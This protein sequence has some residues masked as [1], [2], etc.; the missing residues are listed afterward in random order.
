MR[1]GAGGVRKQRGK[2]IGFWREGGKQVSEVIGLASEMTK[3]D[4]RDAVAEIVKRIKK[5]TKPKLFGP[6]VEGPYFDFYT[7]KWKAST[8]ENNQQ[9]VRTHLVEALR[10]RDM[11]SIRRDE[12]QELLD[13]K[14]KT[15]SFSVVDHLRWDLKQIFDMAIAEGVLKLNPARLLFTPNEAKRPK[16][17]IMTVEQIRKAFEALGLRDRVISKLAVLSGMRPGEIFGLKW[18]RVTGMAAEVTQRVYRG[19]IDTPKTHQSVREAALTDGVVVDIEEWR[20]VCGKARKDDFVFSSERGTALRKD[21]VWRR[22]MQPALAK[23]GLGWCNFQVMRRT[24]AS[25]MRQM[26]ADP[27]AVAAQLGHTVDVSL[28]TYA[29]SPVE[30]RVVLV[31]D[32]ERLISGEP[33]RCAIAVQEKSAAPKP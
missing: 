6:F 32:L 2:W 14:S 24:H 29:Q 28:N 12:L 22:D 9:R 17:P 1:Y 11:A 23:V 3:G 10:E 13:A 7:R 21:N 15:H 4:A 25:L 16:H 20:S 27:H 18:G 19:V 26:K 31:N 5:E 30:T 33:E 8:A